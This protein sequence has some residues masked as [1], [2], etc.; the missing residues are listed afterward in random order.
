MSADTKFKVKI[1]PSD[2]PKKV[3]KVVSDELKGAASAKAISRMK[4]ESVACPVVEKEV[5]FLVCFA[6]P[7]FLRRVEGV[8]DCAGGQGPPK[9]WLLG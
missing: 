4:K 6:C 2:K 1:Y 8:V 9:D 5:A 3:P 7:S